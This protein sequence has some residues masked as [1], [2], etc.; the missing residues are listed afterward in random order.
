MPYSKSSKREREDVFKIQQ[1][2]ESERERQ[3]AGVRGVP[4]VR[5][6][7]GDDERLV[8][9]EVVMGRDT[10][11]VFPTESRA[12]GA[13]SKT[14][15]A[16]EFGA[17]FVTAAALREEKEQ[18]EENDAPMLPLSEV[19]Q[20]ARERKEAEF[21]ERWRAM[22]QGKN[23][24]LD[25]EEAAFYD[26][27]RAAEEARQGEVKR[28]EEEDMRGFHAARASVDADS[29]AI[30]AAEEA[31][32]RAAA[33]AVFGRADDG[34]NDARSGQDDAAMPP[35]SSAPAVRVIKRKRKTQ[36]DSADN[37]RN[38]GD[39][40]T[41]SR[42]RSEPETKDKDDDEEDRSERPE[43]AGEGCAALALL[44]AYEDDDDDD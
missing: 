14:A 7:T 16:A 35:S 6:S 17:R 18:N 15:A 38:E 12:A 32:R 28:Q 19:L 2:R 4:L 36:P 1:E 37:E 8:D 11:S 34:G 40:H 24:P 39:A 30:A 3:M 5:I 33:E 27:M 23:R 25:E 22:K 9:R 20:Q 29:I 43:S 44:A 10:A 31:G 21:E 13:S 26:E 41:S 42:H